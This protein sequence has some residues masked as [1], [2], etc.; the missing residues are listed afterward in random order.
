MIFLSWYQPPLSCALLPFLPLPPALSLL[1]GDSDTA[2]ML[3]L[4]DRLDESH[5]DW[6]PS[7]TEK[8]FQHEQV[9]TT[10]HKKHAGTSERRCVN[11]STQARASIWLWLCAVTVSCSDPRVKRL[12]W[13]FPLYLCSWLNKHTD[14][15][16]VP[17]TALWP[18]LPKKHVHTWWI[19][20]STAPQRRGFYSF[21]RSLR[22]SVSLSPF[23]SKRDSAL[24]LSVVEG[25][26]QP[27]H[28]SLRPNTRIQTDM[29][30]TAS[31]L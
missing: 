24:A 31:Q 23:C 26:K 1:H 11:K 16:G 30:S 21:L 7:I 29:L 8:C 10:L 18:L 4:S 6:T 12:F 27:I 3:Q 14:F 2:E 19:C 15:N 25:F 9:D 22:P 5:S 20:Q 28:S 17:F 13:G